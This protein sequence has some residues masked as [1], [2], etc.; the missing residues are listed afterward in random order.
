MKHVLVTGGNGF[1]GRYVVEELKNHGYVV[2][3][4]DRHTYHTHPSIPLPYS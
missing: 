2:S 4:F 1:I 3:V